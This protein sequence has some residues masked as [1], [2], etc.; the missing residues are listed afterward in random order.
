MF[1]FTKAK[2]P[3]QPLACL[4]SDYGYSLVGLKPD[5]TILFCENRYFSESSSEL[6]SH[7]LAETVD[8]YRL[9]GHACQVILAPSLYQLLLMDSPDV[10][11]EEVAKALRWQLKGLI[12]YPLNDVVV[13]AFLIP[14][15]GAGNRRKKVLAAVT[16]QSALLNRLSLFE[17][18]LLSVVSVSIAELALG[19]LLSLETLGTD[20]PVIVISYNEEQW[21]LQ[22]YFRGDLY[23]FRKLL[24]NKTIIESN[25]S[26]SHDLLLEIQR[27]VDYCL[28]ELKFPEPKNIFFTPNFYEASNL[29]SFL[30]TE[31]EKEVKLLDASKLYS[32]KAIT[33]KDY[34]DAF[35]AFGGALMLLNGGAH[36]AP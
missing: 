18:S 11:E 22:A 6:I 25:T 4:L 1:G 35:Y 33:I 12:D 34:A 13:D 9:Y 2:T 30:Q 16:L 27:S 5:R 15:H 3:T 32:D 23:L 26:V 10:A 14:P 19:A 8:K 20:T 21:E 7:S 36:A 24:I 28:I 17:R 29:L 31:M